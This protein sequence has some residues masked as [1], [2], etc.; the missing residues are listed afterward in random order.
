[1]ASLFYTFAFFLLLVISPRYL[2]FRKSGYQEASGNHFLKVFFDKGAYGEFLTFR[3]LEKMK[4]PKRLLTNLYLPK[5]DGETTEIDLVMI[6][7]GGVHVF[8][9]KN[10][11]GWIFGSENSPYWTQ[12]LKNGEKHKFFNPVWQNRG[13]IEAL[14]RALSWLDKGVFRSYVVFSERCELKKITLKSGNA[15]VIRRYGLVKAVREDLAGPAALTETEVDRVYAILK[16]YAHADEALKQ[17][18]IEHVR[19]AQ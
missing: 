1:M 18:H 10:Y 17:K 16:T 14:S 13:H 3:K 7:R 6:S 11:S 9:S 15:K 12:T 8:E 19:S 5:P 4:E 2:S